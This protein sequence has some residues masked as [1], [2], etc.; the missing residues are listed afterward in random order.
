MKQNAIKALTEKLGRPTEAE[1]G[2]V[3]D[4]QQHSERTIGKSPATHCAAWHITFG[5]RCLNCGFDPSR[6]VK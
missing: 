2:P 6:G 1:G 4:H 3:L 5:G